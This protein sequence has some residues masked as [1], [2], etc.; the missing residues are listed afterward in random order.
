MPHIIR[1]HRSFSWGFYAWTLKTRS[2]A[3]DI[4]KLGWEELFTPLF[5]PLPSLKSYTTA[6]INL[7]QTTTIPTSKTTLLKCRIQAT[8]GCGACVL[9][10]V[11]MVCCHCYIKRGVPIGGNRATT[12]SSE[13][14]ARTGELVLVYCIHFKRLASKN[15]CQESHS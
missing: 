6:P 3:H 14:M 15:H 5:V 2:R 7:H 1:S 10:L 9:C 12:S 13:H 11:S 8:S 4:A